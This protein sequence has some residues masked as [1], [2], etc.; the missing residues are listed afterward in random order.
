MTSMERYSV[1]EP[2]ASP[3]SSRSYR[4]TFQRSVDDREGFWLEAAKLVD[5]VVEPT[6][7]LDSSDAPLYRWF[8]GAELKDRKSVV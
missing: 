8:A 2:S 4:Q 6:T 7:A 5:W 1:S 3:E